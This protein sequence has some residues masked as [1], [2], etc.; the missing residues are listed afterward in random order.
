MTDKFRFRWGI[1]EWDVGSTTIPNPIFQYYSQVP[2]VN[3]DNKEGIGISNTEVMF[4][5]HLASFHYESAKGKSRPSLTTTLRRRMGYKTNQGIINIMQGLEHKNLIVIERLIGER[6]VYSFE[7]FA[8]AIMK[9]WESDNSSAN[10]DQSTRVDQS[11][12]VDDH[13]S[14]KVDD[15]PSTKIDPKN[16][17]KE[18]KKEERKPDLFDL[19]F[20]TQKAQ[21]REGQWTTP[22]NSEK[23]DSFLDGPV[24]AFAEI[25]AKI[26]PDK[27]PP[28]KRKKWAKKLR[29]AA[30]DWSTADKIMSAEDMETAIRRIPDSPIHWKTYSTPFMDSFAEDI[31]S[32]LLDTVSNDTK[33]K[34]IK[35]R[36]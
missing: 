21:Q 12:K 22:T 8:L 3:K 26:D 11:T 32:L 4:I 36:R 1:P 13:P 7:N 15:N 35:L 28:T 19:A 2:W 29:E 17:S 10:V 24:N 5:L 9:L 23:S 30:I 33:P 34:V 20:R 25:C 6:S 14:T 31:G 27:L 16:K 18:E